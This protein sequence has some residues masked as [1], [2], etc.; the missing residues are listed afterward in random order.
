MRNLK[1]NFDKMFGLRGVSL[2]LVG[3]LLVGGLTG[4]SKKIDCNIN[5]DHAHLYTNEE[6]MERY[7]AKE[8]EGYEGFTRQDEYVPLTED[9]VALY[10]FLDKKDLVSLNDNLEFLL[11]QQEQNHDYIEYRYSYRKKVTRMVGK[12][13]MK[14]IVTRYSWTADPN[15]PDLTGETR[16]CHYVYQGFNVYKDDRG[17]Y[18][19]IP[20]EE[21]DDTN[22][23]IGKYAYVKVCYCKIVDLNTG[24]VVNY[25]DGQEESYDAVK[26]SAV[27]NEIQGKPKVLAKTY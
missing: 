17:R 5:G 4:C 6:G 16:V 27:T 8:Y 10:K 22:Q 20:S 15:H 19:A 14:K 7:V 13:P 3:G 2:V 18:V 23:L 9:E 12:V 21:V 1:V 26:Q 25:E 11:A 24:L